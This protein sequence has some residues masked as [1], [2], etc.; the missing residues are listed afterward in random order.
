MFE[1]QSHFGNYT[2]EDAAT[3]DEAVAMAL[4]AAGTGSVFVL[5]DAKVVELHPLVLASITDK[6]RLHLIEATEE[7]KSYSAIEPIFCSL[8]EAGIK[9]NSSLLVIGGGVLQDIGCFIA[10]VLFRGIDWSL[11]PSTLLAQCDSCI[12]SKSSI[13]V[14]RYKNQLGTFNAPKRV[15]LAPDLLKTLPEDEIRSG[16]GEI[17]KLHLVAG[18]DEVARLRGRLSEYAQT[19]LGLDQ[20]VRDALAIKKTFIEE[21]EFDKGRRNLLNYGHTFGHAYESA[22]HYGIPHGIAV[23]LGISTATY[24]SESLGMIGPGAADEID[25]LLS[26]WYRPFHRKVLQTNPEDVLRAM[27]LDKKNTG[28]S[29][30]CIL[31]RGPGSL[32]KVPLEAQSQ[33]RGLL[34][35]YYQ[36]L[37]L[38]YNE[39]QEFITEQHSG[40][41][42]RA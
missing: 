22:T 24:F 32:E 33:V 10:S 17:I 30:T 20:L 12:G 4:R 26:P 2:V 41:L 37:N 38:L 19:G 5:A 39:R 25:E 3:A 36:R 34:D 42:T 29:I 15:F 9:R 14:G 40:N 1:V 13:N 23:V 27:A 7:A 11:I 6:S 28:T 31:T 18:P 16:M 35:Q 8:I 21:D